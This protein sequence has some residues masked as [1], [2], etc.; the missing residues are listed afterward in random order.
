MLTLVI[1]VY[2]TEKEIPSTLSDF[3]EKLFGIVF[4]KHDRLKAGFNRQHH[5]KLSERKLKQLFDCF[6][7]MAIHF[8][9]GRSLDKSKFEQSFDSAINYLNE[10]K[11]E[12]EDFRNDII[13][14]ACLMVEEGFDTT[15][16]LHKSILD[17]HAAS[18]VKSQTDARAR[19]FYRTGFNNFRKWASVIEFL[20]NIDPIRYAKYYSKEC[21]TP[22]LTELNEVIR[23]DTPDQL[24]L[25]IE[26]YFPNLYFQF[27]N[28]ELIQYGSHYE[29]DVDFL[30]AIQDVLPHAIADE[31]EDPENEKSVANLISPTR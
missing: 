12:L 3:F 6:C 2:Q 25:Y 1:I 5:T 4:T 8:G 19:S 23:S 9:G 27:E 10:C 26:K 22:L 17:Y 18:F 28:G 13:M 16:F 20:S 14:V 21:L 31:L 15:T 29:S 11:C 30:N 7:F 24:I